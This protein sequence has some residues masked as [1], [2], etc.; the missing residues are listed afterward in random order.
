MA[1]RILTPAPHEYRIDAPILEDLL[2]QVEPTLEDQPEA[3]TRALA[4]L[5][6]PGLELML[7]GFRH[8]CIVGGPARRAA[9]RVLASIAA[10]EEL[11]E[12]K[13]RTPHMRAMF[14]GYRQAVKTQTGAAAVRLFASN[15]MGGLA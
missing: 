10:G 4:V 15:M 11:P 7:A 1:H 5:V 13:L 6:Q 12:K 9:V 3:W 14:E 8:A 2:H